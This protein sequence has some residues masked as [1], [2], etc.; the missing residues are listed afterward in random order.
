M[1]WRILSSSSSGSGPDSSSISSPSSS[2]DSESAPSIASVSGCGNPGRCDNHMAAPYVLA[3]ASLREGSPGLAAWPSTWIWSFWP[4]LVRIATKPGSPPGTQCAM[5]KEPSTWI[6]IESPALCASV[7]STM[8]GAVV[9]RFSLNGSQ[10]TWISRVFAKWH[11]NVNSFLIAWFQGRSPA[12]SC[13]SVRLRQ[14]LVSRASLYANCIICRV[15]SSNWLHRCRL[16]QVASN[17]VPSGSFTCRPP[18]SFGKVRSPVAVLLVSFH[19]FLYA[20]NHIAVNVFRSAAGHWTRGPENARRGGR[21]M[22]TTLRA[23]SILRSS[24]LYK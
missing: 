14:Q 10:V 20:L 3:I 11:A 16:P 12:S 24:F 6:S 22:E 4:A 9:M 7:P 1:L 13:N 23:W 21:H 5:V 17:R 19:A 18:C 15:P 2:S 8:F